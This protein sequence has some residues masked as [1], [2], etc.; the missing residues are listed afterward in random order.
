V[1]SQKNITHRT[2][3]IHFEKVVGGHNLLA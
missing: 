1:I 3:E 2:R